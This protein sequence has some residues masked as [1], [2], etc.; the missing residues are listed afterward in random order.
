MAKQLIRGRDVRLGWL[1]TRLFIARE[2]CGFQLW[3][4]PDYHPAFQIGAGAFRE[5][6][7]TENR[8]PL[9]VDMHPTFPQVLK[10]LQLAPEDAHR[11]IEQALWDTACAYA[12]ANSE[13]NP[14]VR[15]ALE[16]ASR[17]SGGADA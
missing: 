10:A 12:E 9:R 7:P 11:A 17:G 6:P 14:A 1:T 3:V 2:I 5:A 8:R 15:D 4:V 16:R 13:T